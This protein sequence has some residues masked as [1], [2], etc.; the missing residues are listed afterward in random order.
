MRNPLYFI[1]LWLLLAVNILSLMVWGYDKYAAKR[2]KQR[3]AERTL[4]LLTFFGGSAGSILGMYFFR[5]K[6]KHWYFRLLV[7][8]LFALHLSIFILWQMFL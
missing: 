5:H 6:T 2:K 3:I 1:L 4:L 8:L 7:P